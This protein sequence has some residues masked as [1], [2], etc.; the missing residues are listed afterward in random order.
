MIHNSTA[1]LCRGQ[2]WKAGRI[3]PSG[4]MCLGSIR[5]M[6]TIFARVQ[7]QMSRTSIHSVILCW[8]ES[9]SPCRTQ[10]L[11]FIRWMAANFWAV[12]WMAANHADFT[13][14]GTMDVW[15]FVHMRPQGIPCYLLTI[16]S[17]G[18]LCLTSSICISTLYIHFLKG[19]E[20]VGCGVQGDVC[21]IHRILSYMDKLGGTRGG[22]AR[23]WMR[24]QLRICSDITVP[25]LF[26][27]T[28]TRLYRSVLHFAP[29]FGKTQPPSSF[30]RW[31]IFTGIRKIAPCHINQ[32]HIVVTV[33]V[34]WL[35]GQSAP[36]TKSWQVGTV[37]HRGLAAQNTGF[38][39]MLSELSLKLR[40][41]RLSSY[42]PWWVV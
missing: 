24:S 5:S 35:G 17:S 13:T 15:M 38:S 40:V 9:G 18:V 6:I 25:S 2:Y 11:V 3:G 28:W 4:C 37:V 32:V 12:S 1:C 26:R 36:Y 31:S 7:V 10:E 23:V 22:F 21:R 41:L 30:G 20:C 42:T 33:H 27:N 39:C 34:Q 14:S 8:I 19:L 29:I 16:C